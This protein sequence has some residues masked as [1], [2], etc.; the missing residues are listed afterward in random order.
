MPS[1]K[2]TL[3][4][5]VRLRARRAGDRAGL[6]KMM[7]GTQRDEGALAADR[8]SADMPFARRYLTRLERLCRQHRGKI[9]VAT[10]SDEIVG[11]VVF[12]A[13][14]DTNPIIARN[15]RRHGY[16]ADL[17]VEPTWRRRGIAAALMAW[18]ERDFARRGLRRVMLDVLAN[19]ASA[20][21][22]YRKR[23]F[24]TYEVTLTKPL[25]S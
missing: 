10:A 25:K 20:I 24:Q 22:L 16:I 11:S 19:N 8:A 21:G 18:A 2:A 15:W 7:I 1:V 14:T 12:F 5:G 3:P 6:L 23:K 17:Y 9:V 4:P 13:R